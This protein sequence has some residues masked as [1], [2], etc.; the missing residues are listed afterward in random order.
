MSAPSISITQTRFHEGKAVDRA[1]GVIGFVHYLLGD[2]IALDG[3]VLR[4]ARD[5]H[6]FLVFPGRRRDRNGRVRHHVAVIDQ[7][8]KFRMLVAAV[9]AARLRP[10]EASP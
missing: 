6:V 3:V 5:G 7:N 10:E 1:R 8:L 2:A 9:T 4:H